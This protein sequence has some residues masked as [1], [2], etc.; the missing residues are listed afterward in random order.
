MG[1][2]QENP[3]VK[4]IE[5]DTVL[6]GKMSIRT[7]YH[8]PNKI[9]YAADQ[10]RFGYVDLATNTVYEK[11]IVFDSLKP[12]FRSMAATKDF[13]YILSITNPALL[14]QIHKKSNKA[15]LVYTERHQKVFYDSMKFWNNDEGIALGDPTEDC[16]SVL[17]TRDG[18]RNWQKVSCL[19][20]PKL[21]DGEAAFAASNTNVVVKGEAC[22]I[23]SGGKKAR[24]FYSPD[25]GRSW[26]VFDTPITQGSQM[27][28]IYTA[29][30]Y[31]DKTGIVAGGNYDEPQNNRGN[32]ARTVDG[33]KIWQLVSDD[34]GFGYASCI[35][36][37]PGSNGKEVACVGAMGFW[38]SS[39]GGLSWKKLLD[40]PSLYIIVFAD[41][42]TAYAAGKDKI[43]RI[44]F[45]K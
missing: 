7:L 25:K 44:R 27:S 8:E 16:F 36:Y 29:D 34:S 20:F 13:V 42:N 5:I 17:I 39:D 24:V 21:V 4:E 2:A 26:Q 6:S 14:Y 37:A 3:S 1:N 32:K 22:W 9:W 18:G 28:G 12:E 30:F 33:G 35:Q 11:R 38:Y 19:S 31:D 15:K 45:K 43:V 41:G 40:D 23:V 10:G